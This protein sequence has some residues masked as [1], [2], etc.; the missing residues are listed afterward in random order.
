MPH[1]GS[2]NL[3]EQRKYHPCLSCIYIK[4]SDYKIKESVR[5]KLIIPY[6]FDDNNKNVLAKKKKKVC[7]DTNEY[8]F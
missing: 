1:S 8:I 2:L 5:C 3:P 6:T 7:N 4:I